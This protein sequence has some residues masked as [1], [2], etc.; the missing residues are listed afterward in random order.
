MKAPAASARFW[1][2]ALCAA[3]VFPQISAAQIDPSKLP[4]PATTQIDYDR[5]IKPIFEHSCF[6]CH[7]PERPKSGFRLDQRE[8]AL[9]GGDNG[10]DILPGKSAESPLIHYVAGL[11]PDMEM[12]PQGKGEKLSAT[13]IGLLRA[14]IDQGVPYSAKAPEPVIKF[15]VTTGLQYLSVSGDEQ[16]FREHSW[17]R[18][19]W[20]GGLERLTLEDRMT[21]G[22]IV[23]AEA[24]AMADQ[25]DYL[26][27]LRLE[28]PDLGFVSLGFQQYRRYT[29]DTG[30]WYPGY[31]FA[32]PSLNREL[33][34]DIGRAWIDV[35][36]TLPHWP[37]MTLG[38]EHQYREGDKASLNY[39]FVSPDVS[40]PPI[41]DPQGR[42]LLPS[43]RYIDEE[44]HII[45]FDLD[46]EIAG[47][48]I[49][50]SF[51]GE[52]YDL[53]SQRDR[54]GLL[55]AGL[56]SG[57]NGS[58]D[59]EEAE[60][61]QGANAFTLEKPLR[62]WLFVSG[63]YLYS[64]LS[65]NAEFDRTLFVPIN[66]AAPTFLNEA[67]NG[68]LI[69]QDTHAFNANTLLGPWN[70]L[71][72]Y[73]G[74]QNEWMTQHALAA[75]EI[76]RSLFSAIRDPANGFSDLDRVTINESFG[77]KYTKIPAAV[78]HADFR[79]QQEYIDQTEGYLLGTPN[80]HE[81]FFRDTDASSRLQE[82][83]GGA[84]V[85]PWTQASFSADF[86]HRSKKTDY[87]HLT[88]FDYAADPGE[89]Y[90][91][92]IT[93]RDIDSDGFETKLA[94]HFFSWLRTTLK[95]EL[96]STDFHTV[97]EPVDSGA[98]PAGGGRILAGNYDAHVYSVNTTLTPSRRLYLS[99]TFSYSQSRIVSGVND[100]TLILPYKGDIYSVLASAT[101]VAS[102]KTDLQASYFFSKADYAQPD[103]GANLPFGLAYD[104]HGI[105][106]GVTYH[107]KPSLSTKLQYGFF[108]YDEPTTGGVNNYT[109][110]AVFASLTYLLD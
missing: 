32:A 49:G 89:G 59:H 39:G 54:R 19:G 109:A 93:Q 100:N 110:H 9:K 36:L 78:L 68:I 13:E 66:P 15:A 99:T 28:K 77:V 101:F 24:R 106:A 38:Y 71:S 31:N 90:P 61:F 73:G 12:P 25:N 97:T 44:V 52:F 108:R 34:M 96:V 85:S 81:D 82:Y 94:L 79:W 62:D 84:T 92:F 4:P 43:A 47:L 1:S 98:G 27:K 69:D 2:A 53:N 33:S 11:D 55:L 104:R 67:S 5:D 107:W 30:L 95:Y 26:M 75:N 21:N 51:R 17:M 20:A 105:L 14:W 70:G 37:R 41:G 63:G 46:H 8:A 56:R 60:H 42:A 23:R 7:G 83:R 10:V 88:D 103:T 86:K 40:A 16:K 87:D 48:R 74:L 35:G 64:R 58:L 65:G 50:D 72:F 91:A 18:D 76:A 3:S 102:Q 22:V 57:F 80:D 45:K 6:R 29:D